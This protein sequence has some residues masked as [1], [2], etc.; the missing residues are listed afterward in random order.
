MHTPTR[1]TPG[2][3]GPRRPLSERCSLRAQGPGAERDTQ[4]NTAWL[5]RPEDAGGEAAA[6][7]E[8]EL[9]AREDGEQAEARTPGLSPN[10]NRPL[11]D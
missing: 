3:G 9:P 2:R 10:P 5:D 7:E 1:P 6:S 4:V 11:P 8:G